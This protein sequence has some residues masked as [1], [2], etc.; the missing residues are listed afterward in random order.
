MKPAESARLWRRV[1]AL[2][3]KALKND[4]QVL[5][6]LKAHGLDGAE[7]LEGFQLG[8]SNGSLASVLPKT[9]DVL[10][11]LK[12]MR[13][14]NGSSEEALQ[15]CITVPLMDAE[16][17]GCGFYGVSFRG[18]RVE[19]RYVPENIHGIFNGVAAKSS[20]KLIVATEILDALA[21]WK[22]GF[23]NVVAFFGPMPTQ[24]QFECFSKGLENCEV[25]L[26][27]RAGNEGEQ[28]LLEQRLASRLKSVRV[29]AWPRGINGAREFFRRHGPKEFEM[30]LSDVKNDAVVGAAPGALIPNNSGFEVL[31][32]DR[33]YELRAIEKPGASRLK[34][35]IRALG[36]Q[37]RFVIDT[38]DFYLSR[39]RRGFMCESARLFQQPMEVIE[40]DINRI[41]EQVE[42]YVQSQLEAKQP[43]VRVFSEED[44][45]E[46]L[47]LGCAED[48]MGEIARDI[49]RLGMV[50]E[51]AN[52]LVAYL[53]MTSRK[54]PEPLA[55]LILSGSGAGKSHLQDSV[56]E[57]CP[58]EDIIKLTSLTEHALFYKSEHSLR[59]KVLALEELAGARGA[60]YAIR[61]LI[62]ARK[63]AIETTVRNPLTGKLETQVNTVHG[64]TAIFQTTT[65]PQADAETRS[66]FVL[67]SVDE[68]PEQTR[69]ILRNQ[70]QSH[71]LEGLCRGRSREAIVRRHHAFQRL[72]QPLAI[73]NPFEPLLGY[74]D[75]QLLV[76][77]DHPK[78]LNLILTVAF[79]HQLQRPKRHN[80]QLG[81]YIEV[82]LGDI[83]I[84]N[85][86]AHQLFGHSLDDLSPPARE[87]FRLTQEYLQKRTTRS[88]AD[89]TTFQRRE[90]REAI[91]WSDT[92]LRTHLREL[93]EM[94]HLLHLSG[95]CGLAYRYRLQEQPTQASGRFLAGLK[96]V[97]QLR[98]EA[99]L[100]GLI[101]NP[102]GTPPKRNSEVETSKRALE[103]ELDG[104]ALTTSPAG[105]AAS[106]AGMPTTEKSP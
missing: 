23:K 13:V 24:S 12:A 25:C 20:P 93:V 101:H 105:V 72:L 63:L 18:D 84:A 41:T 49:E 79:L 7:L 85:E 19:E 99:N 6:R 75:E 96:S 47:K 87:L 54:L 66:R 30:L 43:Q 51:R 48:L 67:I 83:A 33:K 90:L 92:R 9:G 14:L 82:T 4:E 80:P 38:I 52:K 29:V 21:L 16:G 69:A 8:Y 15:G 68:S 98:R 10:E 11:W 95:R 89:K 46:G 22:A 62:S 32:D 103:I 70:R 53:V 26:C 27:L 88:V 61:N 40:A 42:N 78:Y 58:E 104:R 77:R 55:L 44:R 36:Q 37:G 71:T 86:L 35:T 57:L 64:P 65:N 91:K 102:T 74:P 3:G 34:A 100:P 5:D 76:R 59:H 39:S 50:G 60:D 2:Y 28:L 81:D 45:A 97:E 1:A 94:E 106:T 17:N 31:Y 56:L 73:V